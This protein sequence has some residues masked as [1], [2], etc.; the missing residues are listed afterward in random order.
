MLQNR[1]IKNHKKLKKYLKTD[2]IEAYRLYDRDMPEYPF[3]IDILKDYVDIYE[4]GKTGVDEQTRQTTT[5]IVKNALNNIG[6]SNDKIILKTRSSKTEK[7]QYEKFDNRQEFFPIQEGKMKFWLN[8]FDYLDYGL[9]L[10]HRPLRKDFAKQNQS[11]KALNLFAYTGSISVAL[12]LGG[13]IVTT[14]DMSNTYVNWAQQNFLLNELDILE[15]E[16]IR[17][18]VLKWINIQQTGTYD[19]IIL[20]PPT[21]SNSKKMQSS[22]DVQRDQVELVTKCMKLL[23]PDGELIFSNNKRNFK[24]EATL[25]E[26]FD[27]QDISLQTI[28]LDFRD[29]KIHKCFKIRFNS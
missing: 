9:F 22:F 21:F 6:F 4:K 16:F 29:Q 20:D 2:N 15:H 24:L 17:A 11:L 3:I 25:S 23:S 10:D 13:S 27:V 7:T 19:L 12:A 14:V 8:P 26:K 18:D 5:T 28:P 1:V